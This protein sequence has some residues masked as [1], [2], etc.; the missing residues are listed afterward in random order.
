MAS[1]N[2]LV[3]RHR[4]VS[5][6]TVEISMDSLIRKQQPGKNDDKKQKGQKGDLKKPDIKQVP[7]SKRQLKPAAVKTKIKIPVK[8]VKPVIKRPVRLIRKNLGI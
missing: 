4:F 7:K 1:A 2:I 3:G 6:S 8:R 5:G